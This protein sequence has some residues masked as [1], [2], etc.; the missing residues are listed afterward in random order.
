MVDSFERR[1][2]ARQ[3]LLY[4]QANP[5]YLDTE[6]TGTSPTSEIIEIAVVDHDGSLLFESRVKPRGGMDPEAVRVHGITLDQLQT[7]PGWAEVWPHAEAVLAGRR[8]GTYNSEFDLRMIQQSHL[9]NWITQRF[10]GDHFFCI[11]KL[12]ARFYGE[13]DPRSRSFRYQTL[14]QAGKQCHIQLPNSH[15]A[16]EDALLARALLEYMANW[17]GK[18]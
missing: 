13:R 17:T 18:P 7:A 15:H 16:R 8:V 10:T 11:M 1:E 5:V 14:D 6:T 12:Y 4:W 9:R 3:A 2:A